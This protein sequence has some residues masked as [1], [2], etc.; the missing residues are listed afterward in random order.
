MPGTQCSFLQVTVGW[1]WIT[2]CRTKVCKPQPGCFFASYLDMNCC[3][4]IT[5]FLL[6]I[7]T[8]CR[9][10]ASPCFLCCP[11]VSFCHLMWGPTQHEAIGSRICKDGAY[12]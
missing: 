8:T 11:S 7:L 10:V 12:K 1:S 5:C 9:S 4:S 2:K 3:P 6:R